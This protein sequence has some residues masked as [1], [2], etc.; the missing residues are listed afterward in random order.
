M[1]PNEKEPAEAPAGPPQKGTERES[2]AARIAENE[3]RRGS[4]EARGRI[5]AEGSEREPEGAWTAAQG[6]SGTAERRDLADSEGGIPQTRTSA[7]KVI[8]ALFEGY[9][10]TD[11]A[12]KAGL[13]LR[14]VKEMM[15][16]AH[17]AS[18]IAER[19]KYELESAKAEALQTVRRSLSSENDRVALDAARYILDKGEGTPTAPVFLQ[20]NLEG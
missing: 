4:T 9:S 11:A 8:D 16:T 1:N 10:P 14:T 20:I 12:A 18:Q 17:F 7:D 2:S 15:S 3:P 6:P 19:C 5:A 13:S